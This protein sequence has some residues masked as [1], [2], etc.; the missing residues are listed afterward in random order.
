MMDRISNIIN[1]I[2]KEGKQMTQ[3]E[4]KEYLSKSP[5]MGEALATF[6]QMIK[7]DAPEVADKFTTK[8]IE[9][10]KLEEKGRELEK[11]KSE[12]AGSD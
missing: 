5:P 6:I 9:W 10:E 3:D 12:I 1:A 4:F 11:L 7:S 8:L 2:I